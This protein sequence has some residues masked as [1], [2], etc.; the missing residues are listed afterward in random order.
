MA[1]QECIGTD[2]LASLQNSLAE[3]N[4]VQVSVILQSV[5][6]S[7]GPQSPLFAKALVHLRSHTSM[8][9]EAHF[10]LGQCY[11]FGMGMRRNWVKALQHYKR[12]AKSGLVDANIAIT[13]MIYDTFVGSEDICEATAWLDTLPAEHRPASVEEL[14]VCQLRSSRVQLRHSLS[15]PIG[16]WICEALVADSTMA[17]VQDSV[18]YQSVGNSQQLKLATMYGNE[19]A[20]QTAVGSK[21]AW[22]KALHQLGLMGATY[23]LARYYQNGGIVKRNEE[24]AFQLIESCAKKGHRASA[25]QLSSYYQY[26]VGCTANEF[27]AHYWYKQAKKS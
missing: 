27:S 25:Y 9:P 1:N 19:F 8:F 16:L 14:N 2:L 23:R 24:R 20:V 13:T 5:Y 10:L 21:I 3:K 6:Q 12:A 26:G 4:A 17:S 18:R 22:L 7:A 15:K 11:Q